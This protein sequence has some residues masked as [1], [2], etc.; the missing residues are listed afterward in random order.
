MSTN[1]GFMADAKARETI[2]SATITRADGSIE[3]LGEIS[4]WHRNPFKRYAWNLKQ[5]LKEIK[6]WLHEYKTQD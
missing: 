3:E 4:Y 6:K 2:I 1:D 5:K